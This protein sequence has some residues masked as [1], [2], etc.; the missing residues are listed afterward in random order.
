MLSTRL[1]I[2]S[3]ANKGHLKAGALARGQAAVE[4]A[5]I[6]PLLLIVFM[7]IVDFSRALND[8]QILVDLTR[9]GSN[10]ASRGTALPA[11]ANAVVQGSAPLNLA[12]NGEIII[13]SVARVNNADKITGQAS[14]GGLS[15]ASKIGTGVGSSATVPAAVDD[16]FKNNSGQT[17]FIT[18]VY[19]SF[20]SVTPIGNFMKIVLPSKFYEVAYF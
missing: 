5:M 1:Q 10:M 3:R 13:T 18:E 15:A 20:K 12:Q 14:Q 4:L 2:R 9:Q 17:V 16:I 7:A 19:Y 8:E 6:T 11:A